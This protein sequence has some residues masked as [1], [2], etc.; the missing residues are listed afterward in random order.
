MAIP[1]GSGAAISAPVGS[2]ELGARRKLLG[3]CER[4]VGPRR[5]EL[6]VGGDEAATD[7]LDARSTEAVAARRDASIREEHRAG[8]RLAEPSEVD[9]I[10]AGKGEQPVGHRDELLESL[11]EH[12]VAQHGAVARDES[13]MLGLEAVRPNE[14][15]AAGQGHRTQ[16]EDVNGADAGNRRRSCNA[17]SIQV[18][19]H[20]VRGAAPCLA[21]EERE[22]VSVGDSQ[23]GGRD[24]VDDRHVEGCRGA[25]GHRVGVHHQGLLRRRGCAGVGADPADFAAR[26]DE[27]DGVSIGDG[28]HHAGLGADSWGER[29]VVRLREDTE[30][31]GTDEAHGAL[32]G[33]QDEHAAIR[34]GREHGVE[35]DRRSDCERAGRVARH[36]GREDARAGYFVPEDQDVPVRGARHAEYAR[37]DRGRERLPQ[38]P[39]AAP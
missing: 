1:A 3:R 37:G 28:A 10:A 30:R 15:D 4:A 14:G 17:V 25:E 21:A 27:E 36:H 20:D 31:A 39:S 11:R 8:S 18:L 5:E 6:V 33:V 19:K 2:D 12:D 24:L 32:G 22:T 7:D 35:R 26:A 16:M 13:G 29:Q 9:E 23:S 34:E 38:A